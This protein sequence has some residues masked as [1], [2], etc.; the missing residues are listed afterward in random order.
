MELERKREINNDVEQLNG[1]VWA[2]LWW[3]TINQ[4]TRKSLEGLYHNISR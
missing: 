4:G 1:G 3:G 2:M